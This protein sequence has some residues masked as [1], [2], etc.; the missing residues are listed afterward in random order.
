[1]L[2]TRT[3]RCNADV[4]R[5]QDLPRRPAAVRL[6]WFLRDGRLRSRWLSEEDPESASLVQRRQSAA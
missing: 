1:M 3:I 6:Q 2:R 4:T 5:R